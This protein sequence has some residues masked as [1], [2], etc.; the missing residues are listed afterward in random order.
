MARG[1]G[2]TSPS[3]VARYLAGIDF[4]ARKR[5]LIEHAKRN[6]AEEE[7]IQKLQELPEEEFRSMAEVMRAYGETS[8]AEETE[9][10][11]E[12]TRRS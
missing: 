2:D 3:N 10:T 8:D 11:E 4:P 6:G 7:V 12:Q 1:V 5:Q 9:D